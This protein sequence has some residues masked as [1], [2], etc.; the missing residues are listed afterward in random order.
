MVR[1]DTVTLAL[2]GQDVPFGDFAKAIEGF[3]G[4]IKALSVEAGG[5]NVDWIIYDLQISSA[6]ATIKGIGQPDS[7]EQ[8]VHAYT[9]VGTALAERRPIP[10]SQKV[11]KAAMGLTTILKHRVEGIRFETAEREIIITRI[12]E[13]KLG[14][15]GKL[16]TKFLP[17]V[18]R[19]PSSSFGCIDGRVQTLTNRG[20]LRFTLYDIFHDKAVSC[21]LKEGFESMMRDAWGKLASVAGLISRDPLTG[22]PLSVRQISDVIIRPEV[23]GSYRDARGCSPPA[24]ALSAEAA[25]RKLRDA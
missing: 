22:R 25:I 20:G 6:V 19:V 9:D 10:F 18:S 24:T 4:L 17:A 13:G 2:S 1:L 3:Y 16:E 15:N 14:M 21:Y 5:G 23:T 11:H 12:S 8:V 7:I